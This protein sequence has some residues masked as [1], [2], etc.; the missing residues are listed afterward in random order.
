MRV[1]VKAKTGAR[2]SSVKKNDNGV[3]EIAVKE[4]AHEN[5]ANSA[6]Q[7]VL[8]DHFDIAPSQIQLVRGQKSKEK[9]F[10][11]V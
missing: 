1:F 10:D 6:I 11:I 2:R 8:A 9:V 7:K 5:R 3:F 4:P